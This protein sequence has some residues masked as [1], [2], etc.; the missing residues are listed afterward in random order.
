MQTLNAT[1]KKVFPFLFPVKEIPD[2]FSNPTHK[3]T[4][5]ASWR[6]KVDEG[7]PQEEIQPREFYNTLALATDQPETAGEFLTAFYESKA[8][9][10]ILKIENL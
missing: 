5:V 2:L 8:E 4:Y 10:Q 3:V 1:L 9:I 6:V 7:T